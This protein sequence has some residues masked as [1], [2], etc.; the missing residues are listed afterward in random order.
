[1]N[2]LRRLLGAALVAALP[3]TSA[4]D[5]RRPADFAADEAEL[6][7]C[8]PMPRDAFA[9]AICIDGLE[10]DLDLAERDLFERICRAFWQRQGDLARDP[11]QAVA[12]L[13][14]LIVQAAWTFVPMEEAAAALWGR[15]GL[16]AAVTTAEAWAMITGPRLPSDQ[17][18][19]PEP[20][21]SLGKGG[22]TQLPTVSGAVAAVDPAGRRWGFE[23]SVQVVRLAA[24]KEAQR[25]KGQVRV[26]L[27]GSF[28]AARVSDVN[29]LGIVVERYE[30]R[31]EPVTVRPSALPR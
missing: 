17:S 28:D 27:A 16:L 29:P 19:L 30:E 7:S 21:E 3:G 11:R 4:A 14:R 12:D 15:E 2:G 23:T 10:G 24:G 6:R 8:R 18:R 25:S 13:G 20:W 31:L 22:V 5:C 26:R 9:T 1:M